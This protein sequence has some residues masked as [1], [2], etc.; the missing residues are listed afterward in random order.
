VVVERA[1]AGG[2]KFEQDQPPP[3]GRVVRLAIDRVEPILKMDKGSP[4][5]SQ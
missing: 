5:R 3:K 4:Q 1:D 2:F